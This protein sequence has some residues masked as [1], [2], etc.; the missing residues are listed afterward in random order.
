MDYKSPFTVITDQPHGF[1]PKKINVDTSNIPP[2]YRE[3]FIR[4]LQE[5]N[6]YRRPELWEE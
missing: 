4:L 2:E 5:L 3:Y 1:T 6:S